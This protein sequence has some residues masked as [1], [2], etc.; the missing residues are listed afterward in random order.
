MSQVADVGLRPLRVFA[1]V[2]LMAGIGLLVVAAVVLLNG[3]TKDVEPVAAGR[4]GSALLLPQPHGTLHVLA[5]PAHGHPF[6]ADDTCDVQPQHSGTQVQLDAW[7]RTITH[8]GTTYRSF[9]TVTGWRAGDTLTCRG[10]HVGDLLVVGGSRLGTLLM[11]GAFG[12][13]GL[14]GIA[15]GLGGLHARRAKE[16]HE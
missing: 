11:A 8:G 4:A 2:L 16:N 14:G 5:S 1:P 10:P 15:L 7:P 3:V 12:V 6:T 9:R 13:A